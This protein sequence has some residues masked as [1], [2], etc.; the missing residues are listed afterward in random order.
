MRHDPLPVGGDAVR[1]SS[2]T[3]KARRRGLSPARQ[4]RFDAWL[5]CWGLDESG[6]VID[7]TTEFGAAW[8]VVLDI[9]F[10]HGESIRAM[11]LAD[12]GTAI[13]GVEI[14]TPGVAT[15][16]DAVETDGLANVRV[17]HG[18]ALV[19]LDRIAQSSLA[20]VRIFFPDPWPKVRQHHRRL[21]DTHVV[22]ALADRLVVGGVLHLATDVADY[23]TV[24]Q[25]V[26]DAD[27]LAQ[28][29]RHRPSCG[30]ADHA[31]R[32]PRPR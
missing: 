32:T 17:V 11:A 10:G 15:L 4:A 21:V 24:M 18:D 22:A 26:C 7:W 23:A 27:A 14:H 3:F 25:A 28:R 30:A 31:V 29:R 5:A 20:G 13:V 16:L 1:R 2:V 19:F 12:P 9:G 8:T 6:P